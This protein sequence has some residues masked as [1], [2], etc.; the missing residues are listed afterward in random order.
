MTRYCAIWVT[1]AR[2]KVGS[3]SGLKRKILTVNTSV[4]FKR[5]EKRNNYEGS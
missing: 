5:G 1:T 3:E 4:P 2:G